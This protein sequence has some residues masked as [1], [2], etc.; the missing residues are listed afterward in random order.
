MRNILLIFENAQKLFRIN[1][2][3]SILLEYK[4]NVFVISI[5]THQKP[6]VKLLSISV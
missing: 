1:L 5:R 3:I 4:E 6:G 2:V